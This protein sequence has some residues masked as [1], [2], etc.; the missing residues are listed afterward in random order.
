[1]SWRAG[2]KPVRMHNV[3][4]GE[5]VQVDGQGFMKIEVPY[6]SGAILTI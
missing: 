6:S 2:G 1:M 3:T 4:V 5:T